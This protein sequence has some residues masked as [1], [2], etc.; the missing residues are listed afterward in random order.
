MERLSF[1][2]ERL[3][4]YKFQS[5]GKIESKGRFD[6]AGTLQNKS[7]DHCSERG[8]SWLYY[9]FFNLSGEYRG[10]KSKLLIKVIISSSDS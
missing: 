8:W 9:F 2:H 3:V 6:F 4:M 5:Y 10:F 1:V 7:Y